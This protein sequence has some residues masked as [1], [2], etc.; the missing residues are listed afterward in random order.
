MVAAGELDGAPLM[1]LGLLRVSA[2]QFAAAMR[3]LGQLA[4]GVAGCGA[5]RRAGPIAIEDAPPS[6]PAGHHVAPSSP[7]PYFAYKRAPRIALHLHDL[8]RRS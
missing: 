3:R 7:P 6:S 8:H 1:A 5:R 4:R 2:A